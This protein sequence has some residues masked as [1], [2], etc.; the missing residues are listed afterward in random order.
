MH[1]YNEEDV[2]KYGDLRYFIVDVIE[3]YE[4]RSF[5]MCCEAT[6]DAKLDFNNIAAFEI[7]H[8]ENGNELIKMVNQESG[9]FR[10]LLM[11]EVNE[12][13]LELIPEYRE[14]FEEALDLYSEE[15]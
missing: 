11:I 7:L 5:Y 6:L 15:E 14:K 12:A 9:L 3:D 8:D 13:S 1:K 4:G 10:D 2:L